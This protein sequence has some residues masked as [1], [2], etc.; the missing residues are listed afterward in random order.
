VVLANVMQKRNKSTDAFNLYRKSVEM[1]ARD[2]AYDEIKRQSLIYLGNLATDSAE[3]APNAAARQPYVATAREAY[4]QVLEDRDAG[5]FGGN[6]R[7]GLCRLAIATGDT[8]SLRETY[9]APLAT[10]ATFTYSDLMNAGVCMARADMVPEATK[11]FQG[12]YEKSPYH[13]D[14]LSN[15]AI[16]LLRE[17]K[18]D[19]SLPLATR[20]VS[21]EPNNPENLQ[22]LVLSYAG[23]AK[24]ARDAR[25]G[26]SRPTATGTKTKTA[27]KTAP[28]RP[29]AP[30][31]SQAASDSLFKI[32]QAFTDSAVKMNERKEKLAYKVQLTDFSTSEEKSTVSG[33]VTN[34]GTDSKSITV[35]VDF[36]DKDGKVVASKTASVGPIAAGASSRF[37]VTTTPGTSVA[38]FRYAI[39]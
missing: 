33:N 21:V 14:A 19:Q 10:P 7:A 29:A 32:E 38:A 27:T 11:L 18:H 3:M 30:R 36:L 5:E 12:A 22:L 17:D 26:P 39:D 2:T 35:K 34:Q 15:L 23:I 28:A 20:L 6:A 13:R 25:L 37:S 24:R 1:A 9:K 4:M 31:L 8:A 16:M